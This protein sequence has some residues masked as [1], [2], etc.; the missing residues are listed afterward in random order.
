MTTGKRNKLIVLANVIGLL[1]S[2]FM[3]HNLI[4]S[5]NMH[6]DPTR[7]NIAEEILHTAFALGAKL[8]CLTII[9]GYAWLAFGGILK[10]ISFGRNEWPDEGED[11]VRGCALIALGIIIAAAVHGFMSGG[12]Y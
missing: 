2:A 10:D 11:I 4:E 12:V 6:I 8:I 7:F 1:V 9:L 3:M 5:M